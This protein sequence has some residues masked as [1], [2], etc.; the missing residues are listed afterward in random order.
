LLDSEG[1]IRGK[2]MSD[3]PFGGVIAWQSFLLFLYVASGTLQPILIEVLTY[4]GACEKST[5]LFI[6]PTYIGMTMSL[7][8]NMD[9]MKHG[10]I[11]WLK[12]IALAVIELCSAALCFTGLVCAGSAV[13]TVIY[14][15]VTVYTAVFSRF[16]FG[17]QLHYLQ[18]AGVFTVMLGL[19]SSS[20]G[21]TFGVDEG[22]EDV[23][24]GVIMIVIGSMFHSLVYILTESIL[25]SEDPVAPEFL[26]S[27]MGFVGVAVF[28]LWQVFYTFPRFQYLILDEI[29]AH[30][31]DMRVIGTTYFFLVVV[32]LVHGLC[33]YHLIKSVGSTT[34][35]ILKGVQSVMVFVISHFAFCS[36]QRSQCFTR[37]KGASLVVVVCGVTFYSIF[38]LETSE[39]PDINHNDNLLN[40]SYQPSD[41][42]SD[43][44]YGSID[45]STRCHS[46]CNGNGSVRNSVSVSHDSILDC[47]GIRSSVLQTDHSS[48]PRKNPRYHAIKNFEEAQSK[49][50]KSRVGVFDIGL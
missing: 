30:N 26:G 22:E 1:L 13:F 49:L 6:L 41:S 40:G 39:K 48:L 9:A 29:D 25:K 32:N 34:T 47:H 8:S 24:I 35:G 7:L 2:E 28:G 18:W 44:Q 14:S 27:F 50:L 37:S 42:D 21:A 38:K 46:N 11:R 4:N 10:K 3:P 15:S 31:G 43:R 12:M 20:I 5:F 36:L 33:F 19:T 17:R 16:F 23:G 45:L